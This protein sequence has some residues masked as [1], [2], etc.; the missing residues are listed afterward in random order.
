MLGAIATPLLSMAVLAALGRD[1]DL[2]LGYASAALP[3]PIARIVE[4]VIAAALLLAVVRVLG[5]EFDDT[6]DGVLYGGAM[7]AGLG[8]A[9]TF[10]FAVN[11]TSQL[12]AA[13]VVLLLLA[14]LNQAFYGAVLGAIVGTVRH[15]PSVV[16]SGIVIALGVATV[17]LL[18][19][20][21]DTLPAILSRVL[22]R[23][24]GAIGAATRGI[25]FTINLL[26]IAGLAIAVVAA[27]RRQARIV[28]RY[29][30]PEAAMGVCT[31]DEIA[32]LASFRARSRRQL[33]ALRRRRVGELLAI[34]RLEAAQGELAFHNWRTATRKR[35]PDP[36]VGDALRNRIK[37]LHEEQR[38]SGTIEPS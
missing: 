24:D 14:G 16:R 32:Q 37:A 22:D 18:S 27:S 8:A 1:V 21:H 13:T 19:A 33:G 6:I 5:H 9:E 31:S 36:R 10:L 34:R 17:A 3:D 28:R 15:W 30:A 7:G 2:P 20:L 29:L 35:P 25:A 23:P 12:G 38:E 26:G 11:G 4:Q